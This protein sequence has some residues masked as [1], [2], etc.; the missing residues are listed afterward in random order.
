[1]T[2]FIYRKQRKPFF[3]EFVELQGVNEGDEITEM[4]ALIVSLDTLNATLNMI[5]QTLR[6]AS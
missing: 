2:K 5:D 4:Q 6:H 3:G 1:M